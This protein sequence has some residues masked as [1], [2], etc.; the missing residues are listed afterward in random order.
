M[1][2]ILGAGGA[3]A[4]ALTH[5][6]VKNNQHVKLV[7]RK[8]I[9]LQSE[10]VVW[11]QADLLNQQEVLA[12]VTGS[13]V[14]YATAGLVYDYKIWQ[15]QWLIVMENIIAAAK[16]TQARLIFFDNVYMYGEV[17][18]TM[19]ENTPYNPC[20]KKGEV[21]AQIATQLMDEA[22][23]GNIKASIARAADF[24]A[25]ENKNSF[26]D[27]MVLD[28]YAHKQSAQWIGNANK[29][30]SFSYIPD[31]GKAMYLLGQ[32]EG[33]T[34][35]IWHMPTAKALTGKQFIALAAEAYGTKPNY[36]AINKLMMN[37]VG[38]FDPLVKS[39]VEM[40]YQYVNDYIFDSTKF[41]QTFNFK[42]TS[43]AD[44]IKFAATTIY[45][46]G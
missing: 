40:Y 18:G 20:S 1:H 22:K 17:N 16:A 19:T 34:N 9:V 38:I 31:M 44:G 24:Y 27:M 12:A 46:K 23:A 11:R 2:T 29:L 30:H 41:E 10:K 3:V 37:L 32:N 33:T 45:K 4:N 15:A 43:Y 36:M 5:Q 8:S 42:P 35:Q 21:R 28:R 25:T 13:E 39:S 6:L 7:S 14:I 26:F